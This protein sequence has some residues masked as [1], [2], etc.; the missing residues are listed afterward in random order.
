MAELTGGQLIGRV[1]KEEGVEFVAGVHGGHVWPIM[2]AIQEQGIKFLHLRHEQTGP[3]ICDGWSRV[4]RRLGVCIGT[5]GPGMHNMV[6]GLAHNCCTRSPVV[7]FV[8]QHDSYRDD[9]WGPWQQGYAEEVCKSFTKWTKRV[10]DIRSITYYT[11]KAFRDAAVYPS[12][13][14]VVEIP[15]DTLYATGNEEEQFGYIPKERCAELGKAEGDPV[16]VE[17]A[18]RMLMQAERPVVIGGD[19]IY[20]SEASEEL[21]EFVELLNIPVH[22]RRMGRGA[23]PEN[24]P[25]AFTGAYRRPIMKR[26]DVIAV[27]GLRMSALEHYAQPPT[28]SHEAK[29]ILVSEA[30]D[31]LDA[32]LPTDIRLLANPKL[33]LR[34]MIDCAKDLIKEAPDRTEWVAE[35]RKAEKVYLEERQKNPEEQIETVRN[36]RPINP[37][38]LAHEVVNFLDDSAVIILDSFSMSGLTTDKIKAKFPGL[39]L[40]GGTDGGV[41]HS[42]GMGIGAQLGRPGKQ[43]LGLLG[44]GGVGIGGFDIE[45]AARYNI[46][47][48][49][50]LLNNSGWISPTIQKENL[51]AMPSWAMLK[52]IRYDIIFEQMGCHTELVTEPEQIRP[53]LERAF[54]SGKTSVIN[55]IPDDRIMP[56]ELLKRMTSRVKGRWY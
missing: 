46:P 30:I 25:L 20:W 32:R 14:V 19:G 49:Y 27:F 56:P 31:E 26:A 21:K 28:Y 9:G 43:V 24:H 13:P 4:T 48:V 11:Q 23:V 40:D 52:D 7:A 29:Y 36:A 3:Y 38:F 1:L 54:N 55:V 44:D 33:V 12:G 41:G 51:P 39:I 5:A 17:K 45:T 15:I 47:A 22:T 42:I 37:H 53:A 6:P 8:G 10:T 18:V 16:V 2:W 35:V 34:Q 50:L